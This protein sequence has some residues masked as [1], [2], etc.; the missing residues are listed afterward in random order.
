MPE[1]DDVDTEEDGFVGP[2]NDEMSDT[3]TEDQPEHRPQDTSLSVPN[4]PKEDDDEPDGQESASK[5]NGILFGGYRKIT[6]DDGQLA[7]ESSELDLRHE[8]GRPSSADGSL[9]TTDDIPDDTPSL[10]V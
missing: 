7:E 5:S 1:E 10:K 4:I 3:G 9:S 2:E 6:H 8:T